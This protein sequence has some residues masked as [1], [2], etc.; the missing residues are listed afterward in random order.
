MSDPDK[1]RR[2]LEQIQANIEKHGHHIYLVASAPLPR[3][4]YTIGL[5][6]I[7]GSEL[8]FAGA[9]FFSAEE[10]ADILNFCAEWLHARNKLSINSRVKIGALGEF[11][12]REVN[13]SWSNQLLLGAADF[14]QQKNMSAWQV[15]PPPELWTLDIPDLTRPWSPTN[16]PAWQWLKIPWDLSAPAQSIATTNLAALRGSRVTEAAR[17]EEDQ[18]E[19]FAGAGPEV[20]PSDVRVVPLATLFA[21][22]TTLMRVVE[23]GINEA[24]WRDAEGGPW[25]L[26]G[27]PG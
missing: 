27:I 10:V 22:D 15:V 21:I 26:W 13:P 8:T 25:H 14:Y 24:L 3:F 11:S 12:F 5:T 1:R 18:W 7:I 23:L 4:A 9:S 20:E 19:L 17:W 16:E 6:P 2:A